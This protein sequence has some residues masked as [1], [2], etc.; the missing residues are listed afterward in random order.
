MNE[1]EKYFSAKRVTGLAVLLALVVVLQIWGGTIKIGATS[2]SFVL[3]PIVLGAV[4]L[5]AGAGAFLGLAFGI[6][7]LIY[8]V[9][10]ADFFT[11]VLFTEHPI[12]TSVLCLGKGAAAGAAAG[13]IYRLCRKKSDLCGVFAA[14]ATAPV[15]NTSLFILG[16]LLM[17]GTLSAHFVAEGSSVIYFLVIGCAGWNFVAEF[18]VNLLLAPAVYTVARVA[19]KSF[20]K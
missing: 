16:A 7:V 1:K 12:I 3:V 6:I 13:E 8:G 10:G 18:A 15:V 11:S 19:G 14:A 4:M 2:L 17:S 20:G 5:G 9:T